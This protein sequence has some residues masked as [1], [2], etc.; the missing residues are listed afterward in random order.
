VIHVP[1]ADILKD[2]D[3]VAAMIASLVAAPP[4]QTSDGPPPRAGEDAR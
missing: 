1:A 2:A 3:G 4:P